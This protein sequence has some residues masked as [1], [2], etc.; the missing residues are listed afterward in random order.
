MSSNDGQHATA[1]EAIAER[2]GPVLRLTLNRPEKR[3]ALSRTLAA[4]LR[5]E[6]DAAGKDPDL[7]VIVLAGN[8][9]TFCAGGDIAEFARNTAVGA[10][11]TDAHGLIDLLQA[12]VTCPLPVVSRV[13]GG[14]FG[15]GV[16]L[17]CATDLAIAADTARFSLSEARLGLVPAVVGPYVLGALGQREAKARM[18]QASPFDAATALRIGLVHEVIP[19]A[20][21]DAAVE[22]VVDDLLRCAP[23]ALATIKRLPGMVAQAGPDRVADVTA[24]LMAERITGDE[25]QEG[26]NAFLEKRSANW[27]VERATHA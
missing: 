17:V 14:V 15:G 12:I 18:L 23:G 24:H 5:R 22:R 6:I 4:T 9:P 1:M 7:R 19:E 13:H 21:L 3:N 27:V 2:D 20:G 10:A 25:G 26:L 8:G 16:G 11:E